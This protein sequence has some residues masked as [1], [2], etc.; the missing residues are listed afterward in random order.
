MVDRTLYLY[1]GKTQSSYT[2]YEDGAFVGLAPNL[3]KFDPTSPKRQIPIDLTGIFR[4]LNSLSLTVDLDITNLTSLKQMFMNC[5]HLYQIDLTSFDTTNITNMDQ[6]FFG[7]QLK[8]L[9]GTFNTDNLQSSVNMF[10]NDT[11]ISDA[12]FQDVMRSVLT[13]S[14]NYNNKSVL[15]DNTL[16]SGKR[17]ITALTTNG[18]YPWHV[19]VHE[20]NNE[21]VFDE[22]EMF[23]EIDSILP[24]VIKLVPTSEGYMIYKCTTDDDEHDFNSYYQGEEFLRVVNDYQPVTGE[25]NLEWGTNEEIYDEETGETV[26]GY[27]KDEPRAH[28]NIT[29][30]SEGYYIIESVAYPGQYLSERAGNVAIMSTQHKWSFYD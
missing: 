29:Q 21:L 10:G 3:I 5:S 27:T 15:V 7:C 23:I 9:V 24:N 18:S 20:Y 17:F 22:G 6:M 16:E 28:W 8:R 14:D 2:K 13:L 30:D 19:L 1:Y 12:P 26:I 25:Y 11:S 4:G